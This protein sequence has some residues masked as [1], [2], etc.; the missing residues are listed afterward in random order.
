[1]VNPDQLK[2]QIEGSI[3]QGLGGA[4]FEHL[5]IDN[6]RVLNPKFSQYRVP[7][8]RDTPPIEV[9]LV[10]HKDLNPTGAGET[11]IVGIAPAIGNA[12]AMATGKRVRSLPMFA[13]L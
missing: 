12:Y 8:F 2:N 9:V 3:V 13:T 11:P 4:M 1:V 5:D 10:D 7:R 6:G